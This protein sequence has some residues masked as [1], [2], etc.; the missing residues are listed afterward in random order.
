MQKSQFF[1][2]GQ[3]L[4]PSFSA[5]RIC[6]AVSIN[7]SL[8]SLMLNSIRPYSDFAFPCSSTEN[9]KGFSCLSMSSVIFFTFPSGSA[10]RA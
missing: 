1:S 6:F 4:K 5:W 9:S 7:S 2:T 8:T 3:G 10:A